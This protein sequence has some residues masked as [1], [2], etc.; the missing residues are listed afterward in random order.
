MDAWDV[1]NLVI[2]AVLLVLSA[3][4]RRGK[5]LGS[6]AGYNT[7]PKAEKGNVDIRPYAKLIS[8][9]CLWLGLLFLVLGLRGWVPGVPPL[10]VYI[11]IAM[12]AVLSGVA[13]VRLVRYIVA[14]YRQ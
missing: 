7:L 12:L 4:Y 2:A 5:W 6:I 1:V 11:A 8:T 9:A 10:G 3:Q 13:V 14:H